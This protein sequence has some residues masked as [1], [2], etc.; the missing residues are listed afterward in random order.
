MSTDK[1]YAAE[2]LRAAAEH[3]GWE[4]KTQD[5]KIPRQY[6]QPILDVTSQNRGE[7]DRLVRWGVPADECARRML[8]TRW[9]G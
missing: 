9:E 1:T 7:Y 5:E 3:Q 4:P 8:Q 2:F 6:V